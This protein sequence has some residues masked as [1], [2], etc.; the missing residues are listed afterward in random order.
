MEMNNDHCQYENLIKNIGVRPRLS[1][2]FVYALGIAQRKAFGFPEPRH[3]LLMKRITALFSDNN[4]SS[5]AMAAF[6][7][8]ELMPGDRVRVRPK[9][10]IEST[11][12]DKGMLKGC[13]F[14]PDMYK[15]CDQEQTVFKVV[16]KFVHEGDHTVR[17]AKNTVLLKDN[18]CVGKIGFTEC[19]RS[20]FYFWRNEWLTKLGS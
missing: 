1:D 19:D 4:G 5:P 8:E 18:Y 13:R 2:M 14:L 10:E 17:R 3:A 11:L 16:R 7:A 15:Y 6:T 20:C 9:Q 12:D